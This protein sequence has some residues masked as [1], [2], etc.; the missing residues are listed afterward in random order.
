MTY[1]LHDGRPCTESAASSRALH[2]G[3]GVFRTL[4]WYDGQAV[5][6]PAQFDKLSADCSAL[7][8]AAPD[9]DTLAAELAQAV[10][11]QPSAAVK[12]IVARRTSG[13]GYAPVGSASER[14][15]QA[16]PLQHVDQSDYEQ[17][18]AAILS[19]VRLST[20]PLLAGV[21][22]LNR[23]DQVLGSRDW[24][25]GVRE[26]LMCDAQGHV[27]CGTRSNLFVVR[28]GALLTPRLD[29]GGVAGIM[30]AKIIDSARRMQLH[31]EQAEL[32]AD[33]CLA[34]DEA[35]VCNAL[36]GIWPLRA[37]GE[38][39]WPGP[40]ALTRKLMRAVAHPLCRPARP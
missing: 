10:G 13:R 25:Q 20:Q 39:A 24:P 26:A 31:I 36:I 19:S 17:G 34:A 14:W 33:E 9:A 3:D 30:R 6:W 22:H 18:I 16:Y 27:I 23:L 11:V 4:L 38:R 8:L 32:S 15:V 2:Y 37:L 7:A 29:L 21:K 28:D 40:G 1:I 5:D 35:F 12:I